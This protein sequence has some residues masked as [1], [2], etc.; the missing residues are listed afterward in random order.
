MKAF[1][2][3]SY[4]IIKKPLI[5][6]KGTLL[7]ASVNQYVFRV[8]KEANRHEIKEAIENVFKV[9]VEKVRTLIVH[10]KSKGFK[11]TM[12]RQANWKK[13][14]VTLS[15]GNKIELFQGGV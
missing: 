8:S 1:L 13:A 5:S 7:S 10:G 2:P 3:K 6:E 9:K 14:Y 12:G 15:S 4:D 11:Q